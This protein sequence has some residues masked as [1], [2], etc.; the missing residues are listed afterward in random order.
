MNRMSKLIVALLFVVTT[1]G[2]NVSAQEFPSP[3]GF[4][5][6]FAGLLS[7]D[8]A[9]K[10]QI[11]LAKFDA[12]LGYEI[13]VVTVKSLE[14]YS[15]EEFTKRLANRWGVGKKGKDNGVMLLFAP[16]ERKIRIAVGNG[17]QRQ[18]P[19]SEAKRIIDE[20]II[21]QFRK[22]RLNDGIASGAHSVMQVLDSVRANPE[23]ELSAT[24]TK[25]PDFGEVAMTLGV[26]LLCLA[27]AGVLARVLIARSERKDNKQSTLALL[28]ELPGKLSSARLIL[29]H[30]DVSQHSRDI[31]DT[32][33]KEFE[34]EKDGARMAPELSY[35]AR[36]MRHVESTVGIA[37][38]NATHEKE[39]ASKARGEGPSLLK[40]FP[41]ILAEA[42]KKAGTNE[43]KLK[44]V[45]SARAKYEEARVHAGGND[46]NW[47]LVY[48]LLMN[49][50]SSCDSAMASA[51][52][53]S[54]GYQNYSSGDD[55]GSSSPAP[56][57]DGGSMG[58]G[59]ASG[60]F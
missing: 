47:L 52:A 53:S 1:F 20:K 48:M 16:T 54:H 40:K 33:T 10:L 57:F 41:E 4:M 3:R 49:A 35:S 24:T 50:N 27:S 43:K 39:L 17:L 46:T 38:E 45:A 6:D 25:S 9:V 15:I 60:D 59:G 42:E 26:I 14:G 32:A 11:E 23:A 5:N 8:E 19:D 34:S 44:Q 29:G 13:T 36:T 51:P 2:G 28:G 21:P 56:P 58:G 31:L 7:E 55:G 30:S 37:L 12:K 22:N 18:L